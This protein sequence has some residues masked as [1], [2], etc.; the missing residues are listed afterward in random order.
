MAI[1]LAGMIQNADKVYEMRLV[2]GRAGLSGFVRWVHIV[3]DSEVP[4][5]MN[6]NELVFT[7]GIGHT[8]SEWLTEF[9]ENLYKSKAAGL[10][11]NIGQ[12][13][14]SIPRETVRFCEQN[15]FPLFTLPWKVKLID[16][17]YD[18]CHRIISSEESETSLAAAMKNLIFQP[19]RRSEYA[20]VLE[21][22]G[23][24]DIGEY[25]VTAVGVE[26]HGKNITAEDWRRIL[27]SVRRVFANTRF[28]SC[29]FV[30]EYFLIIVQRNSAKTDDAAAKL[31]SAISECFSENPD[32]H[33]GTSSA[34][35]GYEGISSGY[36]EA[37]AAMK[38]SRIK[39]KEC[40]NY[41]EIG[42]YKILFGVRS[43]AILADFV[44]TTLG[45]LIDNDRKTGENSAELLKCYLYNNCSVME[46]AEKLNVHRNTINHR[47]K[48]IREFLKTEFT[49]EEKMNLMIAFC[50]KEMLDAENNDNS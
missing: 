5:F 47:L 4:E 12:Y 27:F 25:C 44:E 37:V 36:K 46:T 29:M 6:G 11:V 33:I 13:I 15:A 20:P 2:A 35:L 18:F 24:H 45:A 41:G 38:L 48:A 22:K 17:T 21:R 40:M 26:P 9:A 8:G 31:K 30:Q 34:G 32:I 7:T 43:S 1:T 50:A 16:V 39:E 42:V 28:A 19:Q 23:F 3:E 14:E 10:V 49:E